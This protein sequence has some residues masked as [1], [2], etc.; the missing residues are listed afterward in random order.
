M[1]LSGEN[2]DKLPSISLTSL[3]DVVFILLIFFMLASSF[4]DW[5]ELPI[6]GQETKTSSASSQSPKDTLQLTLL[7][8]GSIKLGTKNI[9]RNELGKTLA[10]KTSSLETIKVYITVEDGVKMQ[11]TLNFLQELKEFGLVDLTL[12]EQPKT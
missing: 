6:Q 3:I 1:R 11:N 12:Q 4:L 8:N 10:A 2:T 7:R 5:R 9:N